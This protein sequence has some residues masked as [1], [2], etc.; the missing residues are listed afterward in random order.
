MTGHLA[1]FSPVITAPFLASLV[2]AVEAMTV[3][4][5]VATVSGWR[6][7]VLGA[8]AGLVIVGLIVVVLGP[9]LNHV[10]LHLL[11]LAIGILLL[12]FGMRWLR[13]AILR[14]AGL[15]PLRDETA[16]FANET[17]GLRKQVRGTAAQFPWI[18]ALTACKAVFLE[19]ME[20][21]FIV[22]ALGGA[23]GMVL[24]ASLGAG[25]AC[26]LVAALGI[27][28]HRPLTKVPENT[29]KLAVG[30]M[31]SAFGV[32]W[33]GEGIGLEWPGADFAIMA[34]AAVFLIFS[35]GVIALARRPTEDLLR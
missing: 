26:L 32:F 33:S 7:A 10:P 19:G 6:P 18:A 23:G 34:F 11:Q 13:K 14:A 5:A 1:L 4:L 3:V 29:L 16:A 28:L 20:V 21:V 17:A 27:V 2:E 15:L 31:L 9:M 24:P 12:L 35:G 22:I 30:V 8:M 25:A